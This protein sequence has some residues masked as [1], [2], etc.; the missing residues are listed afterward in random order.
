MKYLF[1]TLSFITFVAS[2]VGCGG[3][4]EEE[5]VVNYYPLSVGNIWDYLDTRIIPVGPESTQTITGN[6]RVTITGVTLVNGKDVFIQERVSNIYGTPDTSIWYI[7]ET[8]TAILFYDSVND[9]IPYKLLELPLETGNSW[10]VHFP[11]QRAVVLGRS[12]VSVPAGDYNDC[13]EIAYIY[14]DDTVYSYYAAHIG[15]VRES[16]FEWIVMPMWAVLELESA[17]IQQ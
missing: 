10:Y 2:I 9:T 7:A 4:E 5:S 3:D 17:T 13:W 11:Y 12:D 6:F 16:W 15:L 8:D 14:D 1:I